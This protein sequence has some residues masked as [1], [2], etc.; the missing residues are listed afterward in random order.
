[1][2]IFQAIAVLAI[3]SAGLNCECPQ[4]EAKLAPGSP[5]PAWQ[6]TEWIT[7]ESIELLNPNGTYVIEFWATWCGPCVEKMPQLSEI[8]NRHPEATIIALS[9][10]SNLID[11]RQFIE[12]MKQ[13]ATFRAAHIGDRGEMVNSWLRA[14]DQDAIPATF[15]VHQGQLVWIGP[16]SNLEEKLT[17]LKN[18]TFDLDRSKQAFATAMR[19]RKTRKEIN[20]SFE[21]ISRLR[22]T[23]QKAEAEGVLA[24]LVKNH[25]ET[26][27]QADLVRYE[28]LAEDSPT[29]WL[30]KTKS[31]LADGRADSRH[32]VASFALRAAKKPGNA[33]LARTA[34][35]LALNDAG[36]SDWDVLIYARLIYT[37]LGDHRD[38]LQITQRMLELYP[39]SPAKD[40]A[41][42]RAVLLETQR[43]LEQKLGR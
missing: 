23:G 38:L 17:Q 12:G 11:A 16:V 3:L 22:A 13:S 8:A 36:M 41:G 14:A 28:W 42:L 29:D 5:A 26:G 37:E 27:E 6:V 4:E 9:V 35:R 43:D 31:L 2:S 18:S 21:A 40:N 25:S 33:E 30:L 15:I 39:Q 10:D 32:L 24:E 20:Q 19:D 7:G 34:M 1:M